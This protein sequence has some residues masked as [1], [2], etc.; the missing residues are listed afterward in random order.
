MQGSFER[1]ALA[2]IT[3]INP[4]KYLDKSLLIGIGA[5]FDYFAGNLVLSSEKVKSFGLRWL[6]RLIRQPHLIIKKV[7]MIGIL[8]KV[9]LKKLII[10]N[11][12]KK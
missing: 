5:V 7:Q 9:F 1:K 10:Y 6:H 4:K 2:W 8:T 3:L 12:K 11:Y